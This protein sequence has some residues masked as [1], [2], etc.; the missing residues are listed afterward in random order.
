MLDVYYLREDDDKD[1]C[2]SEYK[3]DEVQEAYLV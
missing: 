2:L 1:C 3:Y